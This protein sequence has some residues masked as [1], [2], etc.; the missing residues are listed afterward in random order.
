MLN[1]CVGPPPMNPRRMMPQRKTF[2][3]NNAPGIFPYIMK[4]F[5]FYTQPLNQMI[6]GE[7]RQDRIKKTIDSLYN[8]S[9][10]KCTICGFR[11]EQHSGL[12]EHLDYHFQKNSMVGR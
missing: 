11:F 7:M 8:H 12:K 6:M 1:V 3:F 10:Y 4:G 2:I 5:E 9:T